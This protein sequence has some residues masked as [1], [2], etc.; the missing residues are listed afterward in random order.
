MLVIPLQFSLHIGN[1]LGS[2]VVQ[3]LLVLVHLNRLFMLKALLLLAEAG[4]EA[5]FDLFLLLLPHR[6]FSLILVLFGPVYS[7]YEFLS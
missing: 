4:V 3:Q 2:L 6:C 1:F 5:I 7:I